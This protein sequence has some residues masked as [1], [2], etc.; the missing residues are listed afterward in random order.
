MSIF[1]TLQNSSYLLLQSVEKIHTAATFHALIL[2][3]QCHCALILCQ[4]WIFG[5]TGK[6]GMRIACMAICQQCVRAMWLQTQADEGRGAIATCLQNGFKGARL[7]VLQGEEEEG[8]MYDDKAP[9]EDTKHCH[10]ALHID[11]P[12]ALCTSAYQE[13]AK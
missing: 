7:R 13:Q 10:H 3:C 5:Y 2:H 12:Y 11:M 9:I 8:G 6:C 4:V 1:Y